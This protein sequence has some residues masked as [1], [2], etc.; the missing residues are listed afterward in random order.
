MSQA[1]SVDGSGIS[2]R[3]LWAWFFIA[4]SY[5]LFASKQVHLF[6]FSQVETALCKQ[7]FSL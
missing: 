6:I 1:C 5:L 2:S 4:L 3:A 7:S